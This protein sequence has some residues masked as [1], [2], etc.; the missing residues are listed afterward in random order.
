MTLSLSNENGLFE[1]YQTYGIHDYKT[2]GY[3]LVSEIIPSDRLSRNTKFKWHQD[4]FARYRDTWSIDNVTVLAQALPDQWRESKDWLRQQSMIRQNIEKYACCFGSDL[5]EKNTAAIGYK[6]KKETVQECIARME[7]FPREVTTKKVRVITIGNESTGVTTTEKVTYQNHSATV[8]IEHPSKWLTSEKYNGGAPQVRYERADDATY[9]LVGCVLLYLI[10]CLYLNAQRRC[11]FCH[12]C[13][14]RCCPD[15]SV[16][17][18]RKEKKRERKRKKHADALEAAEEKMTGKSKK[19]EKKK[20]EKKKSQKKKSD[21][22]TAVVPSSLSSSSSSSSSASGTGGVG[23][24]I[25]V[26]TNPQGEEDDDD[27]EDHIVLETEEEEV[28]MSIV[29]FPTVISK[30]WLCLFLTLTWLPMLGVVSYV[31]VFIVPNVIS[32]MRMVTIPTS[33]EWKTTNPDDIMHYRGIHKNIIPFKDINLESEEDVESGH[34]G[35]WERLWKYPSRFVTATIDLPVPRLGTILFALVM[36]VFVVYQL[37]KQIRLDELLRPCM[38][39][40]PCKCCHA[41][42]KFQINLYHH[43][44]EMMDIPGTL[45]SDH[46]IYDDLPLHGKAVDFNNRKNERIGAVRLKRIKSVLGV[47]TSYAKWVAFLLIFGGIPWGS[48][49]VLTPESRGI[50]PR[51]PSI[52]CGC[53]FAMRCLG[54]PLVFVDSFFLFQAFTSWNAFRYWTLSTHLFKSYCLK[55]GVF[56]MGIGILVGII[57]L[58]I[59]N[60][61]T[62]FNPADVGN[63][64][65]Y[66]LWIPWM[67]VCTGMFLIIGFIFGCRRAM[68]TRLIPILTSL[69]INKPGTLVTYTQIQRCQFCYNNMRELCVQEESLLV[70]MEDAREFDRWLKV[71]YMMDG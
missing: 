45:L 11:P 24:A 4:R 7:N 19:S 71:Q 33:F 67:I 52:F 44:G 27:D 48:L 36:D 20:S 15:K 8:I 23:S 17:K 57:I 16:V 56:C 65:F 54:G 46:M 70:F 21:V 58:G 5:C 2:N 47:S 30:S 55:G 50:L 3:T 64:A 31:G 29:E 1:P 22:G 6:I 69:G 28:I 34:G 14:Q 12:S 62:Y 51:I 66:Q 63:T 9:A 13:Q 38:N 61:A 25:V 10:R 53:L 42:K 41:R 60:T 40:L 68:P 37:G 59:F 49:T 26:R 32:E 39:I 35:E 43:S 18:A